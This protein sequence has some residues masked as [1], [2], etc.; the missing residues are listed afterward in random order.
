MRRAGVLEARKR[1]ARRHADVEAAAGV[2]I[3]APS[4]PGDKAGEKILLVEFW[5]GLQ[6]IGES[7][8]HGRVVGPPTRLE[9]E[10]AA[11]D[12]VGDVGIAV[13]GPPEFE[14]GA[15][16]I[17]HGKTQECTCRAI[18]TGV[19]IDTHEDLPFQTTLHTRSSPCQPRQTSAE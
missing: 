5:Y 9:V 1:R 16:R 10:G 4:P 3:V 6:A 17:A 19:S 7:E 11:A 18:E 2:R 12:H 14:R 15:N 13:T 8:R